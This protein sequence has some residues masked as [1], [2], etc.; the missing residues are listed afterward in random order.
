M[1]GSSFLAT[2][3]CDALLAACSFTHCCAF[4]P[5]PS[6][7]TLAAASP[8]AAAAIA[9]ALATMA[10][11]KH[12]GQK[13]ALTSLVPLLLWV[14]DLVSP[15]CLRAKTAAMFD[16]RLLVEPLQ[17][18]GAWSPALT[19]CHTDCGTARQKSCCW[20]GAHST[21]CCKGYRSMSLYRPPV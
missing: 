3:G 20:G 16:V 5:L 7:A 18:L 15:A 2:T 10:A 1:G 11:V 14:V 13:W 12:I 19:P 8:P 4:G 17:K 9:G 6:M 21:G